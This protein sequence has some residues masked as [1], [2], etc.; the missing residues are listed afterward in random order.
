VKRLVNFNRDQVTL[1]YMPTPRLVDPQINPK[2]SSIG[3]VSLWILSSSTE[4]II[5]LDCLAQLF[6][7]SMSIDEV[8]E[9]RNSRKDDTSGGSRALADLGR[10]IMSTESYFHPSNSGPWTLS[11][12]SKILD[13]KHS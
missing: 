6:V 12:G 9:T 7:Y 5:G 1:V 2:R 4:L 10:V 8:E 13:I 11:V 3:Y